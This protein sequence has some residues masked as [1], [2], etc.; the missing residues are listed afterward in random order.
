MYLVCVCGGG[1]LVLC[2]PP[3]APSDEKT[4]LGEDDDA[5]KSRILHSLGLAYQ[6]GVVLF[7]RLA[8][9]TTNTGY[10]CRFVCLP[11]CRRRRCTRMRWRSSMRRLP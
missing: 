9:P 8:L 4:L 3:D 1:V 5:I 2:W 10:E 6:V 11:I 7:L